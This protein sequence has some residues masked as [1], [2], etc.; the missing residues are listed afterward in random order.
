MKYDLFQGIGNSLKKTS[1]LIVMHGES[2][3]SLLKLNCQT[4]TSP[5]C[6]LLTIFSITKSTESNASSH[7]AR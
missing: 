2:K 7:A 3:V 1:S 5:L 6:V 4:M